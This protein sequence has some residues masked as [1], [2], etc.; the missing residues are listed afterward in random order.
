MKTFPFLLLLLLNPPAF[1]EIEEL[2][3]PTPVEARAQV[4]AEMSLKKSREVRERLDLLAVP[5]ES[6]TVK[7][8]TNGGSIRMRR[9]AAPAASGVRKAEAAA[10]RPQLSEE[11][12]QK[13]LKESKA[14][15]SISLSATVYDGEVSEIR[16]WHEGDVYHVLSN[17]PF[18]YLRG[19]GWFE[20][21]RAEWSVMAVVE[22]VNE[23][24]EIRMADQARRFGS[25]Y[26]PRERPDTRVFTSMD[27]PEY[28][29]F[30]A[31]EQPVPEEILTKL[32]ALH[33]YYL[34]NEERLAAEHRRREVLAEAHRRYREENPPG[35]PNIVINFWKVE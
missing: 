8:L 20:D 13:L 30:P 2:P 16:L 5:A 33:T 11:E 9:V 27:L 19:L 1:G 4:E 24:R 25:D 18:S 23:G 10:P 28:L 31:A 12:F 29:I 34:Q 14:V 6:E 7:T 35:P 26:L 22:E 32:D 15:E 17:V 21:D 3:I